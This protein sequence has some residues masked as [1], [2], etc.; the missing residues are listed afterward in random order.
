MT[1]ADSAASNESELLQRSAEQE[2]ARQAD[3]GQYD[4]QRRRGWGEAGSDQR[5]GCPG[6]R[7]VPRYARPGHRQDRGRKG[8]VTMHSRQPLAVV[9][10]VV[11]TATCAGGSRSQPGEPMLDAVRA[12]EREGNLTY[13][14]SQGRTL[15]LHYCATCHGDQA[16]GDGQN[17][18]NLNP[19]PPDLT[20]ISRESQDAGHIRRV[21][22]EGSAAI[23]RSPQS[24]PWGRNL[25][26]QQIDYLVAY[27]QKLPKAANR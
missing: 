21:I 25:S 4:E 5:H 15:F 7:S 26:S 13:A 6:T 10:L 19:P 18:S 9:A 23:G 3:R 20:S 27:C 22:A 14:E 12:E 1:A 24:P 8:Q 11:T 2:H 16:R 17:A